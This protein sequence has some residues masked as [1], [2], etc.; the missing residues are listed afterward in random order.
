VA[1]GIRPKVNSSLILSRSN[2]RSRGA[3]GQALFP[4]QESSGN[5]DVIFQLFFVVET[6]GVDLRS[7]NAVGQAVGSRPIVYEHLGIL[8][9]G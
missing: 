5:S 1:S 4:D 3:I 8:T 9:R 2:L 6:S 7:R